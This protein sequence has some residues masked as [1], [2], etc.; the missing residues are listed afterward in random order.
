MLTVKYF[1][2]I[3]ERIGRADETLSRPPEVCAIGSLADWLSSRDEAYRAA[4]SDRKSIRVARNCVFASWD[5]P[6]RDGDEIAFFPPIT[7]G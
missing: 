1:A 4:L 7:G 3:R 2:T 5:T 6:I